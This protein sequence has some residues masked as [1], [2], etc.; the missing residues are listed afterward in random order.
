M[1]IDCPECGKKFVVPDDFP[2]RPFC[3]PRCKKLDLAK[4]FDEEYRIAG[5]A[6]V[7]DIDPEASGEEFPEG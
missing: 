4:W 5:Q 3:S 2:S 7:D 6:G 1:Q